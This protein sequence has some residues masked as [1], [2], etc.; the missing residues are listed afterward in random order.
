MRLL[1]QET[2]KYRRRKL[3]FKLPAIIVGIIGIIIFILGIKY[4]IKEI[5]EFGLTLIGTAFILVSVGI[6]IHEWLRK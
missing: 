6:S 5:G 4:K 2:Q 1:D 3:K